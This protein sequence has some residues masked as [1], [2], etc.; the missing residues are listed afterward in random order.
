M[1][2]LYHGLS[3]LTS[4]SLLLFARQIQVYRLVRLYHKNGKKTGRLNSLQIEPPFSV[5]A[6][7]GRPRAFNERPYK[8]KS[9]AEAELFVY[10]NNLK[11]VI[12]S[13]SFRNIV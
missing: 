10:R 7:S 11:W 1:I 9:P 4:N 13:W 6:T 12:I 2:I 8:T 3:G 5:G